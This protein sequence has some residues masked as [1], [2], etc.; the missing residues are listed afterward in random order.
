MPRMPPK[1]VPLRKKDSLPIYVL[2]L[3][4]T[5]ERSVA[6]AVDAA[7]AK[8]GRIDVAHQQ[9]RLLPLG[10]GGSRHHRTSAAS[11]GPRIS[12]A[13]FVVKSRRGRAARRGRSEVKYSG[14][15]VF[16]ARVCIENPGESGD[17]RAEVDAVRT[18]LEALEGET[19]GFA[20]RNDLRKLL[21]VR[22]SRA[23]ALVHRVNSVA[24]LA[25]RRGLGCRA[26]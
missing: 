13:R 5:D 11:H 9:R 22:S 20:R 12:L 18:F 4:V 10:A 3:D 7:V 8:A 26:R 21:C 6:R 15:N 23:G 25:L 2:E 1:S 14:A 24:A 17:H 16:C 19:S